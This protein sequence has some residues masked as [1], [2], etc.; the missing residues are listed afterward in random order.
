MKPSSVRFGSVFT[1]FQKRNRTKLIG[2]V[3][4]EL[5]RL[6]GLLKNTTKKIHIYFPGIHYLFSIYFF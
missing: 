3:R 4:F 1:I 5:V 2:L 6:I